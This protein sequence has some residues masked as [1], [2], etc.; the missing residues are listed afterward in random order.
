LGQLE[1]FVRRGSTVFLL[2][3]FGIGKSTILTEV[4]R[5]LRERGRPCGLAPSTRRLGDVTAALAAAYPGVR[6]P[7]MTQRRLR[8]QLRLAVEASPGALLLDHVLAAGTAMKGYLRSLRGTGLGVLL[9]KD[10]ENPRDH[11][12]TRTLH[13]THVEI[14]VPPLPRPAMAAVLNAHLA[15]QALPHPLH[16]DDRNQLL[17]L[18]KGNP[19]RLLSLATLLAEQRFW[20]DGRVLIGS[21]NGAALELL[22]RHYL[23]EEG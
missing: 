15:R 2:G 12:A 20:R 10:V 9:A 8:S 14:F 22:L 11:A 19:G 18:A 17:Q 23:V 7:S 5:K 21:L 4:A 1:E 3:P 13:L 16:P 6:G